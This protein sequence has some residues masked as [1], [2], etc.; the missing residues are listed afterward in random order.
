MDLKTIKAEIRVR[1]NEP[2]EGAPN[3]RR[4]LQ[5]LCSSVRTFYN[6]LDNSGHAWA[7]GEYNLR[8]RPNMDSY[9]LDGLPSFGRPLSVVTLDRSNPSYVERE[10]DF[11]EIQNLALDWDLPQNVGLYMAGIDGGPNNAM[12]V[13][14]Y[15]A[16][17]GA[18]GAGARGATP[19]GPSIRFRPVP[20]VSAEYRL[21]YSI[22]DWASEAALTDSPALAQHHDLL[23]CWASLICLSACE[24]GNGKEDDR[25]RRKELAAELEAERLRLEPEFNAYI[26][27]LSMG[28]VSF[29]RGF[30]FD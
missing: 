22:G 13:A 10:I 15:H 11:Y 2:L 16:P 18:A 3:G 7:V 30:D 28:K 21:L 4:L 14:F 23:I 5:A 8:V 6:R 26:S 1:L 19:G 17:A 20:Q 25:D 24:W 29:A 12:R 27:S 9:V